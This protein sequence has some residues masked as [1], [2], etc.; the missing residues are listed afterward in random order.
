MSSD[1]EEASDALLA[2][3]APGM[4]VLDVEGEQAGIVGGVQ[5]AGTE[6]L[7]EAPLGIAEDLVDTGYV[8]I[9]GA[10]HLANDAY[11]G[12]D[13]I[14]DVSDVVRLNVRRLDLV[15]AESTTA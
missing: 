1:P 2:R 15:R 14:D 13:Q 11:A 3:I 10:G 9:D 4:A 8:L 12:G 6:V 7:P 5:F